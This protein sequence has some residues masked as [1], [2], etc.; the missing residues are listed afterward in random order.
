M[1]INTEWTD[2]KHALV[3]GASDGIGKEIVRNLAGNCRKLT[4]IARRQERLQ[5]LKKEISTS[6]T[7]IE[8]CPMNICDAEEMKNL[9]KKIYETDKDQID[10][11]INCAG[12]SHVIKPFEEMSFL[13]IE[14]IFDTNAKAPIFWLRKLLPH[15]K[16]NQMKPG[17]LKRGHIIMM[18][19]RSAERALPNLSV[20]ASA[21]GTVEKFIE[22]MQREYAQY[23]LVFTLVAPGSI[24]T[25]FTANWSEIDR[26]G[27][28]AESMMVEEAILPI[29]QALNVEYATNR[30]SYE[31]T[32]QWLCELGVVKPKKEH[33]KIGSSGLRA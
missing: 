24:N 16:N 29:I 19:S 4:L 32:T 31:S 13:D 9:I 15:M 8:L 18:S 6:Q 10:I 14:Q 3:T 30:I 25:S 12:G 2:G 20:Y 22:A 26:D 23:R 28:N 7:E 21:K 17:D 27:H 11:F 5:E 33:V 1:K